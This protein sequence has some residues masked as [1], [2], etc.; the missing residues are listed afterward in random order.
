MISKKLRLLKQTLILSVTLN[1][2]FFA[3]FFYFLVRD[4]PVHFAF[5]AKKLCNTNILTPTTEELFCRVKNGESDLYDNFCHSPEFIVL[6]I[7]IRRTKNDISQDSIYKLAMEGGW[8]KLHNLYESQKEMSDFSEEKFKEV[9]IAYSDAGS[10]TAEK[11]LANINEEVVENKQVAGHFVQKPNQGELRPL[12]R[13][14]PPAAP[15]PRTHIVQP[16]ESL[17][18]IAKKYHISIEELM[19]RNNLR[20]TVIRSGITLHLP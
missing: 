14:A 9:L 10:Q 19:Q 7:L 2:V 16:G 1:V 3:L 15:D 13:S 8:E 18:I 11:L 4:D 20:S 12:F 6:K 17:W 5:P